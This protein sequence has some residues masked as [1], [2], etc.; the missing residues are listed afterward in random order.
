MGCFLFLRTVRCRLIGYRLGLVYDK[1]PR[2]VLRSV[3]EVRGIGVRAT[4]KKA[5]RMG[6]WITFKLRN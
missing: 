5:G 3:Q 6:S 4:F 2:R 1:L